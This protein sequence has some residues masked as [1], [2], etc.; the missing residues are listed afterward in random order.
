[1]RIVRKLP[2][3]SELREVVGK[4]RF[5]DLIEEHDKLIL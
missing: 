1:M 4:G 3:P 5:E 2:I